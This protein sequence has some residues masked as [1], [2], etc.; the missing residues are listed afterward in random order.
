MLDTVT[1]MK[2]TIFLA[3]VLSTALSI[4]SFSALGDGK[5]PPK[6]VHLG[7][8]QPFE[9]TEPHLITCREKFDNYG[10]GTNDNLSIVV[11]VKT[12]D[13][14]V[15]ERVGDYKSDRLF[16]APS[17]IKDMFKGYV[18]TGKTLHKSPFSNDASVVLPEI[19]ETYIN[20]QWTPTLLVNMTTIY[21]AR[22]KQTG[23]KWFI[24]YVSTDRYIGCET[25]L[26]HKK[27][28]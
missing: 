1:I 8:S 11:R 27:I 10:Q 26:P 21:R 15:T 25:T 9:I 7:A 12:N 24:R 6:P 2:A 22:Y 20:L 23:D 3:L 14:K 5:S 17:I 13:L 16:E 18:I 28:K 19:Q 4:F